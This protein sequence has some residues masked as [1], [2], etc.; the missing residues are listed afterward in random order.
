MTIWISSS[1]LIRIVTKGQFKWLHLKRCMGVVADV[2]CIGII[3]L[4]LQLWDPICYSKWLNL[5]NWLGIEWR[6]AG[7][8]KVL[9][10][11]EALSR[12]VWS[13]GLSV[14]MDIANT[15]GGSFCCL[16]SWALGLLAVIR[17][18]NVWGRMVDRLDLYNSLEKVHD[19]F[20][21]SWLKEIFCHSIS[22]FRP[23]T[24][25]ARC[26]LVL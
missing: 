1:F 11:F 4:M 7:P 12:R 19:V 25:R 17:F 26:N 9:C 2:K 24:F 20:H 18:W 21:V 23:R 15:W 6:H 3:S 16:E 14:V 8:S 10:W 22:Y 5:W 13:G